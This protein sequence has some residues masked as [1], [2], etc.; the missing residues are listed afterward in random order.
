[1]TSL[2]LLGPLGRQRS[3]SDKL[4][5]TLTLWLRMVDLKR[6][7]AHTQ[8]VLSDGTRV[9]G[10]TTVLSILAKPALVPW[11]NRLGLQGIDVTK[12]VDELADAGTCAHYLIECHLG[13]IEPDLSPFSD[14]QIGM[15]RNSLAK[16]YEWEEQNKPQVVASEV[17][18]VSEKYKYGGTIDLIAMIG[19]RMEVID[20]KTAKGLYP[21]HAHQLAAYVELARENGYPV[22]RARILR[23]GRTADEGFE[24]R[25]W[26]VKELKENF[27]L[28]K[29]AL[30][31][32]RIQRR[33][34]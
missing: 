13:S 2:S 12:Y 6:V 10:V 7:K 17:P 16:F 32:Y 20:F 27:E 23:I 22:K 14:E 31:I 21:E 15:A 11:A 25:Q 30:V 18:L 3:F 24:E 29:H 1:M 5:P 4:Y 33:M 19:N 8:Y 9:P 28:F 34:G 26:A